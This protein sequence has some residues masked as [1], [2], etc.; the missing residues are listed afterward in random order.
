ME[1]AGGGTDLNG[2]VYLSLF[3]RPFRARSLSQTPYSLV[4]NQK[5]NTGEGPAALERQG[6]AAPI[7]PF[8]VVNAMVWFGL[9]APETLA[10]D[11][12][13]LLGAYKVK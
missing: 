7:V 2:R 11:L 9:A 12:S 10:L 5:G 6:V 8:R 4:P 3:P 13:S 1:V